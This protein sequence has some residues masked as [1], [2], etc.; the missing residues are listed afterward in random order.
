MVP[1]AIELLV[2]LILIDCRVAAVTVKVRKLE[3]TPPWAAVI[4]VAPIAAAVASPLGLIVA[5]AGF[6][7]THVA[8]LVRF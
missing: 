1:P 6:E 5:A 3:V 8:E 7:D 2:A 4:L